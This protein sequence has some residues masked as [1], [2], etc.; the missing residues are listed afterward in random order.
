MIDRGEG[1]RSPSIGRRASRESRHLT[2]F[3]A[4]TKFSRVEVG[5]GFHR[6]TCR[7]AME[8]ALSAL[9]PLERADGAVRAE[10]LRARTSECDSLASWEPPELTIG[11]RPSASAALHDHTR[12]SSLSRLTGRPPARLKAN[13]GNPF[14]S[15][16]AEWPRARW[17]CSR[18]NTIINARAR[19]RS[20]ILL[21]ATGGSEFR[22]PL[23]SHHPSRL[24]A[25][26]VSGRYHIG[27]F[28]RRLQTSGWHTIGRP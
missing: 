18:P 16:G 3:S 15:P 13:C 7:A 9:G 14:G 4:A 11:R 19:A 6:R 20:G 1:Q 25:P 23:G 28:G 5:R 10:N 24:G 26:L 8:P 2:H 22:Q 17:A 27:H 21:A 12:N